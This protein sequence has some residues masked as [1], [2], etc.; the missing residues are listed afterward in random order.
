VTVHC[1]SDP[2]FVRVLGKEKIPIQ[3]ELI[4]N[5]ENYGECGVNED[6][7]FLEFQKCDPLEAPLGGVCFCDLSSIVSDRLG[8]RRPPSK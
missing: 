3:K 4:I 8:G 6:W 1:A 7:L 5:L 2:S